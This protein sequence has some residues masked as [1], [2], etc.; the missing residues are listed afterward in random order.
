VNNIT[1]YPI[2][3]ITRAMETMEIVIVNHLTKREQFAMAAMGALIDN[4]TLTAGFESISRIAFKMADAML[5]ESK[6]E[7]QS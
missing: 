3:V 6:K 2:E 4:Q 1:E 7:V 5:A